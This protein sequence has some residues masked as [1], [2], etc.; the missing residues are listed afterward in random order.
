M[1][2][3]LYGFGCLATLE[4]RQSK[5]RLSSLANCIPTPALTQNTS[6]AD[7]KRELWRSAL[8]RYVKQRIFKKINLLW[9]HIFQIVI[10]TV[11]LEN[12]NLRKHRNVLIFKGNFVAEYLFYI[13]KETKNSSLKLKIHSV[14]FAKASS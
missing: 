9:A 10:N 5:A 4:Q 11:H 1:C 2:I 8:T 14:V 3:I 13:F 7:A 12:H 6:I